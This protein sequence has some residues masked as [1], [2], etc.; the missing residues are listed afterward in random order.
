MT[1]GKNMTGHSSSFLVKEKGVIKTHKG[2]VE[3][4][5]QDSPVPLTFWYPLPGPPLPHRAGPARDP[6]GTEEVTV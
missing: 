3:T 5:L 1:E 2:W 4:S 6:Q